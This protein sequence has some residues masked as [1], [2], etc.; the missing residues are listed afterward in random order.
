MAVPAMEVA[1]LK[2]LLACER[3]RIG[4]SGPPSQA[5]IGRRDLAVSRLVEWLGN[6]YGDI[7]FDTGTPTKTLNEFVDSKIPVLEGCDSTSA[8]RLRKARDRTP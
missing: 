1:L 5:V 3:E 4:E 7:P 8:Q 2:Y 6:G